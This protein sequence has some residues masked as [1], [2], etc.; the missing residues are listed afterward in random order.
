MS[1]L[2]ADEETPSHYRDYP[3][4]KRA[5]VGFARRPELA[6]HTQVNTELWRAN[7]ESLTVEISYRCGM[8][9]C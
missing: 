6:V 2:P 1:V 7:F 5:L 4:Y 9:S 8:T 3:L